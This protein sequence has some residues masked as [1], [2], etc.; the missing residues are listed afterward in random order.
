M[1]T[2]GCTNPK[3]KNYNPSA[4][5]EDGSCLYLEKVGGVCYAFQDADATLIT[6]KSLT[7]SYSLLGKGWVFFHDYIPNFYFSTKEQMYSL[8]GKSIYK[9]NAGAPGRYYSNTPAAFHVDAVFTAG[10]DEIILNSISWM[11][12]VLNTDKELE[13]STLTH[14]T[15]RNNQQCTGRITLSQ[16]FNNLSYEVRK[17]QA[18]WSFDSFRDMVAAYGTTFLLDIFNN[19]AVDA[20]AIDTEKPWFDQDLL[21]DSF[22]IIRLEFDNTSG[23]Q[24]ILHGADIDASKSYR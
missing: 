8:N 4:D 5:T 14:I 18:L 10:E 3:A 16:V 21:H 7:L 2:L 11:T 12:E 20:A 13:F 9:H 24:L 23:K 6:N 17:T 15:I 1:P 22:F 19:F